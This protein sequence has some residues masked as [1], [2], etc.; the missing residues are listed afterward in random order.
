MPTAAGHFDYSKAARGI[1]KAVPDTKFVR[2][3][4]LFDPETNRVLWALSPEEQVPIASMTKMMT[5]LVALEMLN[6]RK[7][8]SFGSLITVSKTAP[9][10]S[11][12]RLGLTEGQPITVEELLKSMIIKSANDCAQMVAE[13]FGNGNAA[14]FIAMMNRRAV[15]LG[16]KSTRFYNPHGLPGKSARSDNVSSCEDMV[17]LSQALMRFPKAREWVA[18]KNAKIAS[19][20]DQPVV[21]VN[22]N[23]LLGS[24]LCPGINGIKT[25]FTQRAGFC[26]AA[27]CTRTTG[28]LIAVI[29]GFPSSKGR[30]AMVAKLI[31]WGF[32]RQA[33]IAAAKTH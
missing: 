30:D 7:D 29:T 2:S 24:T 25:G 22:H 14:N 19:G 31:N 4:I 17:I 3:G 26:I 15:Q 12:T 10:V 28:R 21:A 32:R 6:A 33:A 16:M 27:N 9:Q 1:I 13:T 8:I 23:K 5:L 11:P 20:F 18:T